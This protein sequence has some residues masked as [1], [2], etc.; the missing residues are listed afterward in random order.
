M[1]RL[2]HKLTI[3]IVTTITINLVIREHKIFLF[4]NLILHD[5]DLPHQPIIET[6]IRVYIGVQCQ[7][8]CDLTICDQELVLLFYFV[9]LLRVSIIIN[10]IIV[11]VVI[12]VMIVIG[13][14]SPY[15]NSPIFANTNQFT[16]FPIIPQSQN[17]HIMPPITEHVLRSINIELS[18]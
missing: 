3:V 10:I 17:P 13:H 5:I 12:V 14:E 1:H 11:V 7:C 4:N 16:Q 2:H 18:S 8:G 6:Y 15:S 9:L